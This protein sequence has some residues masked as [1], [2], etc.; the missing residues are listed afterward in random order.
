K[1][2]LADASGILSSG[3]SVSSTYNT[4]A[5]LQA[6]SIGSK[7]VLRD[8][9]AVKDNTSGPTISGDLVNISFAHQAY[10]PSTNIPFTSY[11]FSFN[12]KPGAAITVVHP[13]YSFGGFYSRQ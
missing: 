8:K 1:N 10:T 4:R 9:S 2:K 12:L 11:Q 13:Y 6:L 7:G 5:G 3:Y